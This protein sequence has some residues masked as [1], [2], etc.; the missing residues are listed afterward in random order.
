MTASGP[1]DDIVPFILYPHRQRY[2]LFSFKRTSL[3]YILLW[4]KQLLYPTILWP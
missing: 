4:I 1:L 2:H 3:P